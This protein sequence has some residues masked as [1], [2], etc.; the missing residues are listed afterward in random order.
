MRDGAEKDEPDDNLRDDPP[1]PN[2]AEPRMQPEPRDEDDDGRAAAYPERDQPAQPEIRPGGQ[3]QQ[4]EQSPDEDE[5]R[6]DMERLVQR[7]VDH[8]KMR[9]TLPRK[10]VSS[11]MTWSSSP[12]SSQ[13]PW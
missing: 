10:P 4:A 7:I 12:T 9:F 5:D 6:H 13:T 2:A 8:W 11:P 3:E 1:L